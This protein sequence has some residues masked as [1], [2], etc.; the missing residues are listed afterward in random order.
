MEAAQAKGAE[1]RIATVTGVSTTPLEGS[2]EEE[3]TGEKQASSD[4]E[5]QRR[6]TGVLL[7]GGELIPCDRVSCSQAIRW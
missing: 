4:Q 3:S 5:R 6:I 1:L 7:E 2:A